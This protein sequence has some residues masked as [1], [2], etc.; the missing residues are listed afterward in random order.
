MPFVGTGRLPKKEYEGEAEPTQ[1]DD[2][3]S[4]VID[5]GSA[6]LSGLVRNDYGVEATVSSGVTDDPLPHH[7]ADKKYPSDLKP[8]TLPSYILQP[9]TYSLPPIPCHLPHTVR[10]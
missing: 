10:Q 1:G 3:V 6:T 8:T 4:R 5:S 9:L 2:N 7:K